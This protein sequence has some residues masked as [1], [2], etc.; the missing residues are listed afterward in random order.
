L[1]EI[2]LILDFEDL[3]NRKKYIGFRYADE[4]QPRY[5]ELYA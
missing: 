1:E 4:N 5:H 2:Q 3:E